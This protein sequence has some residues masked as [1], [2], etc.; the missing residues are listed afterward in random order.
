[1]M[2]AQAPLLEVQDLRVEISAGA[3]SFAVLQGI[4]LSVARGEAVALVGESGCGKTMTALAILGL[5]PTGA[6]VAAGRI[7]LGGRDLARLGE[8]DLR[9]IR[10][11]GIGV[12]FQEPATALDPVWTIGGHLV[13]AI[14]LHRRV[15]AAAARN[16][17]L[18]L[19]KDVALPDP[20][21]CFE[22]YP[23]RLSG[24]MRQRAMIAV[25]LAAD[26]QLLIADEPTTALDATV[27]AEILDLIDRLRR[28]R[29]LSLLLISHDLAV[30]AG[31]CDRVLVL[32]AGEIVE[33]APTGALFEAPRHPYT[34]GLLK[35]M[36]SL[37]GDEGRRRGR[38]PAILGAPP[39]PGERPAGCAFAPRCPERFA[40]C[41]RMQPGLYR[42]GS[43]LARCFLY[44]SAQDAEGSGAR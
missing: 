43:S 42:A 44:D 16:R 31:R 6:R 33:Q 17:G 7:L 21:R 34:R 19:L 29:G 8:R 24:G 1:M 22:E 23:H 18:Q 5:L 9:K 4:D 37:L 15:S 30:V 40:P 14:R 35:S 41:E 38:Y 36:P 12:I 39:A 25:A 32:Y 20:E 3:R 2:S 11:E 27:Q 13:E 28:D 10:G 26:P